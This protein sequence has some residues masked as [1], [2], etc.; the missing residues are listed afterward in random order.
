M[1]GGTRGRRR[2]R[3]V[4]SGTELEVISDDVPA[5]HDDLRL[6]PAER[7][8]ARLVADGSS[9]EEIARQRGTSVRTVEKQVASCLRRLGARTRTELIA[10]L[11]RPA[12]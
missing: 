11:Q 2:D 12:G 6:T 4:V 5:H 8:V 1:S 3:L 9:N 7:E 10:R